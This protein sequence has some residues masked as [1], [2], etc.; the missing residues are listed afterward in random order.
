MMYYVFAIVLPVLILG[1]LYYK[2]KPSLKVF[3]EYIDFVYRALPFM[4]VYALVLYYLETENLVDSGYAFLTIITFLIPIS[5]IVLVL[6]LNYWF[7]RR[8]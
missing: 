5:I 7:R 8:R 6:K 1:A 2:R 3:S 4:A